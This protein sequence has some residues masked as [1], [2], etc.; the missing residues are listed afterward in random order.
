[1]LLMNVNLFCF[2]Y[3]LVLTKIDNYTLLDYSLMTSP[4]ITENYIDLNLKVTV[5][6]RVLILAMNSQYR[7]P[8]VSSRAWLQD[9]P[10][11]QSLGCSR[12]LYKMAWC[13]H[14]TYAH[15]PVYFKSSLDYL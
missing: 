9:I 13:L 5:I 11:Y 14:L 15:P 10:Q 4:E 7:R 6:T 12:P 2:I 1:M 3:Y 8:L